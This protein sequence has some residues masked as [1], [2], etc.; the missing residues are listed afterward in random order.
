MLNRVFLLILIIVVLAGAGC[1]TSEGKHDTGENLSIEGYIMH[2]KGDSAILLKSQKPKDED[3]KLTEREII[4]KYKNK[5]ILLG[6][7]DIKN[8][9]ELKKKQ[10]IKVWFHLLEESN[11]P[12][13]RIYKF[14]NCKNIIDNP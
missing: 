4:E 9:E 11:P 2:K 5:V 10:K 8:K 13:A 12:K 3:Y 14:E 6:L 1:Q 7:S